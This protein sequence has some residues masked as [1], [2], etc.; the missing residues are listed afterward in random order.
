MNIPFSVSLLIC[1]SANAQEHPS[2]DPADAEAYQ[3][4]L[5]GIEGLRLDINR[6]SAGDLRVL[7]WFSSELAHQIET[8]RAESG[9]FHNLADLL[10]VDGVT[11]E[12]LRAAEPYLTVTVPFHLS[13]KARLRISEHSGT[14]GDLNAQRISHRTEFSVPNLVDFA[15]L[16]ERDPGES[17]PAD[18][19]TGYLVTSRFPG[20]DRLIL[21]DFRPGFG[22]G[23]ILSR[24]QR[25]SSVVGS[26]RPQTSP[27]VAYRSSTENG[28][29]RGLYAESAWRRLN[30]SAIL[31][32]SR[33]DAQIHESGAEIKTG[34]LHS[35]ETGRHRKDRLEERTIG[36]RL[37]HPL[38]A[39]T[40]G[41]TLLRSR[42]NPPLLQDEAP[43]RQ[44][45]LA[46]LDWNLHFG[47]FACFGELAFSSGRHPAWST[48][49]VLRLDGLR[50]VGLARRY[51]PQFQSLRG[52][53]FSAYSGSPENE[54]GIFLGGVWKPRKRMKFEASLDRYGRI[55]PENAG[56]LPPRGERTRFRLTH[57][58]NRTLSLR[59]SFGSQ[60]ETL[61]ETRTRRH[62]RTDL[63]WSDDRSRLQVWGERSWISAFEE[64]GSGLAS[65]INLRGGGRTGFQVALWG[66][67]Y[68]ISAYEA[69]IYAFVPSVWGGS[70]LLTLTGRGYAGGPRLG[71]GGKRSRV[72]VRYAIRRTLAGFTPS[73]AIQVELGNL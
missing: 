30:G 6:A 15:V 11:R 63:S 4:T 31:S 37:T 20:T 2:L 1:C 35:T 58:L 13:A 57:R 33:W 72:T 54:W 49:A 10:Q 24:H 61:S 23:L 28:A 12:L 27:S 59:L 42:F 25:T 19:W 73:W 36:I 44:N 41:A 51:D 52:R 48:G 3:E 16:T 17:G 56:A 66:A 9:P 34:G 47:R 55:R 32:H 53:G 50:L 60:L 65:G 46:G 40:I 7:P 62:V 68:T 39:A 29:L 43:S 14:S 64:G 5:E 38:Y 21:G 18:F 45:D 8:H 70:Q 67:I 26:A 22:Q 71:W 69:R